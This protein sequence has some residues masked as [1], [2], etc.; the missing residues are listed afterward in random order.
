MFN[1][2]TVFPEIADRETRTVFVFPAEGAP[3]LVPPGGYV[4][5]ELY[6]EE[7]RCDCRRVMI[8]VYS[9]DTLAHV[10]T[11]NHSFEPPG[12]D[13]HVAEQTFLDP[14]NPQS[15][16]AA[17]LMALFLHTLATDDEY[18]RRLT[19]HYRI[20][21]NAIDEPIHPVHRLLAKVDAAAAA[22]E[23]PRRRSIPTP[24]PRRKKKRWS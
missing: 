12:P 7:R 1:F 14:L 21:K 16:W 17:E 24:P 11:I 22:R 18:R 6:C 19:R 4:F 3:D 15:E 2:R 23:K 9:V 20:F 13:A 8:N 5:D 10:A